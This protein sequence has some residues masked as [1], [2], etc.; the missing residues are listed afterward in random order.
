MEEAAKTARNFGEISQA[1]LE[2]Q[3]NSPSATIILQGQKSVWKFLEELFLQEIAEFGTSDFSEKFQ[4][5]KSLR[6]LTAILNWLAAADSEDLE[7]SSNQ[8]IRLF[9]QR[10][11]FK[12]IETLENC[13][14]FQEA[15]TLAAF[16]PKI[17]GLAEGKD[18][19]EAAALSDEI[20]D[21]SAREKIRKIAK[22][23]IAKGQARD[24]EIFGFT[25]ADAPTLMMTVSDGSIVDFLWVNFYCLRESAISENLEDSII[26]LKISEIAKEA[27]KRFEL[28]VAS[29][30]WFLQ[31][32][33]F[34]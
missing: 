10:K 5:R 19:M 11:F 8:L 7:I 33:K 25:A 6:I 1:A 21:F 14:K 9:R 15:A 2:G 26:Y 34:P 4:T 32:K 16:F 20:P 31:V 28:K 3:K 13:G 30:M 12:V 23:S 18:W 27:Q 24:A 29:T 17:R 22:N